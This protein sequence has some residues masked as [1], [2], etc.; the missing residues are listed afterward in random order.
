MWTHFFT[1]A[2]IWE[3]EEHTYYIV[4]LTDKDL[5]FFPLFNKRNLNKNNLIER[6]IL[7]KQHLKIKKTVIF[8]N[9]KDFDHGRYHAPKMYIDTVGLFNGIYRRK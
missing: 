2:P 4:E 5:N 9:V 6:V 3:I 1:A 7:E 8:L